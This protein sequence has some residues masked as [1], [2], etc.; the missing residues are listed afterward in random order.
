MFIA[1]L[2]ITDKNWKQ[3]KCPTAREHLGRLW[4][5]NA[6]E[7]FIAIKNDKHENY[8]EIRKGQYKAMNKKCRTQ[9]D[10]Y[11]MITTM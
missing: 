4:Y 7:C 10:A 6:I 1:M 3:P 5:I 2:Y 9:N 8:V 11:T